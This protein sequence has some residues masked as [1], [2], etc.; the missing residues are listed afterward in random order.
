M[1]IFRLMQSK[2]YKLMG[3]VI[4]T[5]IFTLLNGEG[6]TAQFM[7]YFM[8]TP[9]IGSLSSTCWGAAQTGSRDQSNGL[10]DK[11]LAKYVYWDGGILKGPDST[12]Y[13][14]AARWDQSLGHNGW[15][16]GSKAVWATSKNLY[17]PYTEKGFCFTDNGNAGHNVNVI[18][19]KNGDPCGYTYGM[20]LSGA[21]AG[22]GRAYGANSLSGP[23]TYI[24]NFTL[25][26][27]GYSGIFSVNDNFRTFLGPDNKYHCLCDRIGIAD[28]FMGP[29]KCQQS[30]GFCNSVS[31]SPTV[32]MEDPYQF[33]SGGKYHVLM[34][35]WSS[36]TAYSYTSTDGIHFTMDK[37]FAYQPA[38]NCTR[39][40][41]GTIN[42]WKLLER[43]FAYIENGHVVA[44]TFAAINSEKADDK[45]NDQNGSKV[46][47]VPFDGVAFDSG[48]APGTV[49]VLDKPNYISN[50]AIMTPGLG[51]FQV[52]NASDFRGVQITN[53]LG[54][55]V[56]DM[57][58]E[59]G[60]VIGGNN[61][62]QGVYLMH[63]YKDDCA[64]S[65]TCKLLVR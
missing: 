64:R 3:V 41:G 1:N 47:V 9:I 6:A 22:S 26:M 27:N 25:D 33:Y 49:H 7:D 52:N 36:A 51:A 37:G 28:N 35:C 58:V 14:F 43:P 29:Y 32:N 39:Y 38:A 55:T 13:M 63:F 61:L 65:Q 44:F 4:L 23:W 45:A 5:G 56:Q 12:Y 11:T 17:G 15:M 46:I 16:W 40:T 19:L 20:T 2:I 57:P 21:V 59:Y 62:P 18:K 10:E 60:K 53:L 48:V 54:K 42:H 31:G 8:P 50:N 30:N 24:G 34:N